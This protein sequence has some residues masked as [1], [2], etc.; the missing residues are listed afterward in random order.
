MKLFLLTVVLLLTGV[1]D[2]K[3]M[4]IPD[5]FV[6]AVALLGVWCWL[7]EPGPGLFERLAGAAAVSVPMAVAERI[8]PGSFGYGDIKLC[9][10]AG[11]LLGLPRLLVAFF[12]A[13]LS[14]GGYAFWLLCRDRNN[15]K[16][17][18]AFGPFLAGGIWVSQ[19]F[20]S[21]MLEWYLDG[22]KGGWFHAAVL[23]PG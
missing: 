5:G 11:L 10:A 12:L 13:V 20:G 17:Q 16:R 1:T 15:R 9:A 21:R 23:L 19:V 3:R 2:W 14:G 6:L 4:I 7:T 8:W 18:I 22:W